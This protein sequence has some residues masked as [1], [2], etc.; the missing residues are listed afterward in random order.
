MAQARFRSRDDPTDRIEHRLLPSRDEGVW[1]RYATESTTNAGAILDGIREPCEYDE[2]QALIETAV[3]KEIE[4]RKNGD[5]DAG[6][7]WH[8]MTVT[9]GTDRCWRE[10]SGRT[11]RNRMNRER[12]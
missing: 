5:W 4:R 3:K 11:D 12:N 10:G 8:G 2:R 7:G 1:F 6:R 9:R